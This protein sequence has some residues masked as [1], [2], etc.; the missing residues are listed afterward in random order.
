M[1]SLYATEF[2]VQELLRLAKQFGSAWVKEVK[3]A[4]GERGLFRSRYERLKALL[5]MAKNHGGH[6][7][8]P[9]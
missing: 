2:E 6:N 1:N 3:E 7:A 4:T 8:I 9:F 5:E